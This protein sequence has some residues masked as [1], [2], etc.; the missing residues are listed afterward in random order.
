MDTLYILCTLP[1]K[2]ILFEPSSP[3]NTI[4]PEIGSN[5]IPIFQLSG[6]A[7]IE[8]MIVTRH[9]VPITPAWA[10]TEYK[11]QGSTY[12]SVTVDL[13]RKTDT[14]QNASTHHRNCSTYVQ[15]TRCRSLY[16][17]HLLQPVTLKDLTSKPD[18]QLVKEDHRILQ[19]AIST[20]YTWNQIQAS[21]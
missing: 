5:T 3:T 7:K 18:D 8:N 4:F 14:K 13:H 11:A 1:P 10:I 2:C 9:Q 17:L 16:G 6:P 12:D 19:L 15:L 20:E 21:W